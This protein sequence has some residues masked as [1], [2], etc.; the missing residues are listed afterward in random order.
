M[1]A[2]EHLRRLW[3]DAEC[4]AGV[5]DMASV[6]PGLA[7]WGLMTGVA[8]ANSGM[9]TLEVLMMGVL[10]YA[11]SSQLAAL[12]LIAAGAPLWVVLATAFCVNLRFV[13][14]SAHLREYMM[15]LSLPQR[16]WRGYL[17]TDLTYVLFVQRHPQ[18]GEDAAGHQQQMNY[19]LGSCALG[20]VSWTSLSLVGIAFAHA[21]PP[22]WGLGFAGILALLGIL[23]SLVSTRLR[24]LSAVVAGTAAVAAFALP[25]KLNILVGIAAAV[26]MCMLLEK[27]DSSAPAANGKA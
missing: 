21:I 12:P 27:P 13:V 24:A 10:V 25:L 2:L 22:A 7:S 1:K 15:H 11:G 6:A 3:H 5:R 23:C 4:R 17:T 18:P 16:L 9:S 19:L 20:W 8:M 14:F 26:C